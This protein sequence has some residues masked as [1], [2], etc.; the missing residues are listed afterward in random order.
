MTYRTF[1]L[2]FLFL[3]SGLR[4]FSQESNDEKLRALVR[5][6]G[7]AEVVVSHP[8]RYKIA[9]L[10]RAFSVSYLDNDIVR[11]RVSYNTVDLFIRQEYEYSIRE[12]VAIEVPRMAYDIASPMQWDSYP[13]YD[14]YVQIMQGFAD[15]YPSLC[16]I[17]TIG[18]SINGK[19]ILA[20]KISDNAATDEDEPEVFYT[21]TMHGDETGGFIMMLR[22]ADYLLQNYSSDTRVKNLVDNLEI[23]I[24]PLSNPDG[25]YRMGNTITNP[26]RFN[27]NGIDLNRNFPDPS[28][29]SD[30]V[31]Q[32]ET[33]DMVRFLRKHRFV[34][35]A[36]FH[37]GVEVVNYPWDRWLSKIHA[38]NDWF[39]DISRA[40]A[41]TAHKYSTA[42]YMNEFDNGIVRGAAWYTVN[43]GRQDF[44]VWELQGREVTIELDR[45]YITPP[46]RL[47][48][49][50]ESNY[51]S[52]LGYLENALYGVNGKVK[53][54]LNNSPVPAKIFIGG[55]DKD[56]SHIYSD[57]ITGSFVR[58]LAPGIYSLRFSA[59][60]YRDTVINVSVEK[61]V[62][63]DLNVMMSRRTESERRYPSLYPN[64]ASAGIKALLP[65]DFAGTI[66]VRIYNT[67][68]RLLRD[69]KTEVYV[70][71]P[72][73][74]DTRS[75]RSGVYIITF[76]KQRDNG[77][78]TGRFLIVK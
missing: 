54:A 7:E 45:S 9:F 14:Q 50:W 78:L 36:N 2:Y 38:D 40:Y 55:Y 62:R 15:N 12:P 28:N 53:D 37:S 58:M 57:T 22:L 47:P 72:L 1:I 77:S 33:C 6:Y 74:I 49:L 69:Y 63:T 24:N 48:M 52:L 56:S 51:R 11:V 76:S 65:D 42:G 30:Y 43:G 66:G 19:L 67:A 60:G 17:D 41:D 20:L 26:S 23:W 16:R 75:F 8:G 71:T 73:D 44:V 31:M 46:A 34:L 18:K 3:S 21:T 4:I 64:P 25:T 10:V 5:E 32:P 39:R 29:T 13:S 61:S 70:N 68:G 59:T 35:S 27:A